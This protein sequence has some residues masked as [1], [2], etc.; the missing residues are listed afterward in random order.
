MY[1]AT[2]ANGKETG[3]W[4]QTAVG[5][6][7][8]FRHAMSSLGNGKVLMYGGSESNREYLNDVWMYHGGD[9]EVNLATWSR[10]EN[11]MFKRSD[12]AMAPI[13]L[14]DTENT[15][16]IKQIVMFGGTIDPI[17]SPLHDSKIVW[18]MSTGCP[19]GSHGESCDLCLKN[20]WKSTTTNE[21]T[22]SHSCPSQTTTSI[23]AATNSKKSM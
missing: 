11:A 7:A 5:P 14:S 22:G 10:L 23:R 1:F 20:Q 9:E 4:T 3:T 8:R 2:V 19:P 13:I 15:K 18:T 12:H 16:K 21:T 6:S 17:T